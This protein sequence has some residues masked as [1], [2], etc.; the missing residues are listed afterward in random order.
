ML[1]VRNRH[2][3]VCRCVL[4]SEFVSELAQLRPE[5][6][7]AA[8]NS[9]TSP[10]MVAASLAALAAGG[11]LLEVGKRD[12]WAAARVVQVRHICRGTEL[13]RLIR[14]PCKRSSTRGRAK[15]LL[16]LPAVCACGC[17]SCMAGPGSAPS[18]HPALQ[19]YKK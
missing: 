5:G 2:D 13:L 4:P 14:C 12:V 11:A 7:A 9:L 1:R 10:G 17:G 15:G 3:H 18:T 6:V 19:S 8:L 16:L